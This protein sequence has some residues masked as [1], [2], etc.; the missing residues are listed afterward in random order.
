[1]SQRIFEPWL[2][3]VIDPMRTIATGKV[4]LGCFRTMP[5]GILNEDM[6]G[7]EG[8]PSDKIADFGN[9]ANEYYSIP[10]SIYKSSFETNLFEALFSSYW[11]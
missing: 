9:H 8:I 5:E 6:N 7:P 1:M 4:E 3:I 10:H 11:A 2:A